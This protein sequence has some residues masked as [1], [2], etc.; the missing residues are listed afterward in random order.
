MQPQQPIESGSVAVA[1]LPLLWREK[2]IGLADGQ[3][4]TGGPFWRGAVIRFISVR[5]S[6]A[7]EERAYHSPAGR[8]G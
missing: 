7:G 6:N 2:N 1:N 4:H 5:R 3:P 8:P